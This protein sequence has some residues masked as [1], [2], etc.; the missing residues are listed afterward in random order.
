MIE[1]L[2]GIYRRNRTDLRA[3]PTENSDAAIADVLTY[4]LKNILSN[5]GSDAEETEAFEDA[6]T[7]GRGILEVYPDFDADIRG[8]LKIRQRP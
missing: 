8:Q 2:S 6:A 4:A 5:T 1:A 3:Y 7:T